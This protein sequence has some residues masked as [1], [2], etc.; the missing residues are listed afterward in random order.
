[1]GQAIIFPPRSP[2]PR[3]DGPPLRPATRVEAKADCENPDYRDLA[4]SAAQ[5]RQDWKPPPEEL[6]EFYRHHIYP[7]EC[8]LLRCDMCGLRLGWRPKVT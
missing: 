5:L 1:M 3:C 6:G 4:L 2:C 7:A 8:L